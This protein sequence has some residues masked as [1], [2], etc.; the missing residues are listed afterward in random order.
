[1]ISS[2][3]P[4]RYKYFIIL[5]FSALITSILFFSSFFTH[6]Q[7]ILDSVLT[8]KSYFERGTGNHFHHIHPW[9]YYLKLFI[10][11]NYQNRPLWTE[12]FFLFF[13]I[14]GIGFVFK[15]QEVKPQTGFFYAFYLCWQSFNLLYISVIPY[16]TPW[17]ILSA[18]YLLVIM[19]G[20]G[21]IC[22]YNI[23]KK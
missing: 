14:I 8:F 1:M 6:P 4:C 23:I 3:R 5:F 21:V 20:Y 11:N 19:A 12:A 2:F 13:S 17:S 18:W 10:W 16:K 22:I 9:Y 7:G 15:L